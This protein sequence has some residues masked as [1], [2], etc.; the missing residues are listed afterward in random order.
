MKKTKK[1]E[2]KGDAYIMIILGIVVLF[3]TWSFYSYIEAKTELNSLS[4]LEGQQRF[5]EKEI[6]H[7]VHKIGKHMILPEGTLPT[8]ATISDVTT[9]K[10]EQAFFRNA[11]NGDQ[12][13]VYVEDQKAIIYRPSE[14]LIVNVG[15]ISAPGEQQTQTSATTTTV[16]SNIEQ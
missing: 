13:L 3:A 1:V 9:L 14:D 5:Q 12:I 2:K 4:S 6:A 11:Q 7:V 16:S 8:M 15:P 10:Q